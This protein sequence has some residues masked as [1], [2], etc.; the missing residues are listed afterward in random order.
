MFMEARDAICESSTASE[1][2]LE[3]G[4][5]L[6][7]LRQAFQA[8]AYLL[9]RRIQR[10]QQGHLRVLSGHAPTHYLKQL[11]HSLAVKTV[12]PELVLNQIE[13]VPPGSRNSIRIA[14]PGSELVPNRM[15]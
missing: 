6:L 14:R 8:S 5:V 4:E 1:A 12:E 3:A 15:Q 2:Q 10:D 7:E 9:L 13:V 11:A